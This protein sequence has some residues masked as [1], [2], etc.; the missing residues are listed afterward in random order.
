MQEPRAKKGDA[1]GPAKY[2]RNTVEI[3]RALHGLP[4]VGSRAGTLGEKVNSA[5]SSTYFNNPTTAGIYLYYF[6][7]RSAVYF[8]CISIGFLLGTFSVLIS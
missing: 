8:Y 2:G 6:T 3:N 5:I 4:T 1:A 7:K